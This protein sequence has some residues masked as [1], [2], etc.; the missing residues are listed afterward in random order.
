MPLG[1]YF[2]SKHSVVRV[3][4]LS[5]ITALDLTH[6]SSQRPQEQVF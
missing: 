3:T 4:S 2:Y 5:A 6:L 1:R